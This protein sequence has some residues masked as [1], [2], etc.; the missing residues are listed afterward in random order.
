MKYYFKGK[1]DPRNRL[2]APEKQPVVPLLTPF[3]AA[4]KWSIPFS[5]CPDCGWSDSGIHFSYPTVDVGK[6]GVASILDYDGEEFEVSW[7]EFSRRKREILGKSGKSIPIF[8]GT[9]FGPLKGRVVE[10]YNELISGDNTTLEI[11]EDAANLLR[12]HGMLTG[13]ELVACELRGKA[14]KEKVYS[15]EVFSNAEVS[16]QLI[17]EICRTCGGV[18]FEGDLVISRASIPEGVDL[19][20]VGYGMGCIVVSERF[21][22]FVQKQV[23]GEIVSFE[24]APIA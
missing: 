19:F 3:D 1:I 14:Y 6:I 24:P 20:R 12:E 7:D 23:W 9:S 11:R 8:P 13:V 21:V 16:S 17:P 10:P 18:D 4:S 2:I 5:Q 22:D 15:V